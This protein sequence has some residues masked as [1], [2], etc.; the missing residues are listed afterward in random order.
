MSDMQE[1][2][3]TT[4]QTSP[5]NIHFYIYVIYKR[6]WLIVTFLVISGVLSSVYVASRTPIYQAK[7][8]V[9]I[10]QS[11]PA[12]WW[13]TPS[14]QQVP[15]L[16]VLS[17]DTA[18]KL[19]TS[20]L[21]IMRA[22]EIIR[23]KEPMFD[24]REEEIRKNVTVQKASPDMVEIYCKSPNPKYA[25][26]IANALA[27]A[28]VQRITEE[29]RAE[30]KSTREFIEKQLKK[31]EADVSEAE[32]K[33]AEFKRRVG[34]VD[35]ESA[36]KSLMDKVSEYEAASTLAYTDLL[37][38]R[39]RLRSLEQQIQRES[40]I[41]AIPIIKEHPLVTE[42]KKQLVQLQVEL[43][44]LNAKYNPTHPAIQKL[45]DR[46]G[47][48][49]KELANHIAKTVKESE[50]VQ[51]PTYNALRSSLIDTQAKVVEL[52]A[53]HEAYKRL[54]Q[55][56]RDKLA[57]IPEYQ[58]QLAELTRV[59][60]V[61]TNRYT[62]LLERLEDAR[63][64][65]AAKHGVASIADYAGLPS[66]PI[67]LP[68]VEIFT[69]ACILGIALAIGLAI[70][71]EMMDTSV[72]SPD[73]LQRISDIRS[74]GL[75]PLITS[76]QNPLEEKLVELMFSKDPF[77]EAFRAIRSNLKF[78]SLT[79]PFRSILI[80]SALPREGKSVVVG[81]LGIA[82][83]QA[84]QKVIL[85]DTDLRH[86]GLHKFFQLRNNI[87]LTNV[88]LAESD[89]D[90]ALRD[91]GVQNLRIL[92]SGPIPPNPAE[93]LD[94]PIMQKIL[95]ELKRRA[96]VLIFDSP[97]VLVV[98]DATVIAP[99]ID[100]VIV[101]LEAGRTPRDAI[102]RLKELMDVAQANIIGAIFNKISSKSSSYYY[103]YYY[104]HYYYYP[105]YGEEGSDT[106]RQ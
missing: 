53:K 24:V 87:G 92:P 75:V 79:N 97:P 28:L 91:T 1:I 82:M 50:Y 69:L 2:E 17:L 52:E 93:L 51:N 68:I 30:A 64:S 42:L 104:Y 67:P 6:L 59:A 61:A 65:E 94:S 11:S 89:L 47:E 49:K 62:M 29:T 60:Q 63:I 80:T 73:D 33:I 12:L 96:D 8:A 5:G 86:P 14:Q 16:S 39:S 45:K 35:I 38:A 4:I 95:E 66:S 36:A 84:G 55:V 10:E 88:L 25:M 83:A 7:S 48:V 103:Y 44:Q 20:H 13:M 26:L 21:C 27:E 32:R 58:R 15:M 54:I 19:I 90:S 37:A 101:V 105:Y 77:A 22:I 85:V 31:L 70:L 46:I 74:L 18:A 102:R 9:R 23:S 56:T 34:I 41:E 71:F 78:I 40:K 106:E 76:K 81:A 57:K 43:V 3:Q 99:R 100:G 72:T 98:T